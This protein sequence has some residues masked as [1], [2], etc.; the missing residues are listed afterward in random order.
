MLPVA[1]CIAALGLLIFV[2]SFIVYKVL[3]YTC[4]IIGWYFQMQRASEGVGGG[5]SSK[6]SLVPLIFTRSY[7]PGS[8]DITLFPPKKPFGNLP[9]PGTGQCPRKAE[10]S[11]AV[12]GNP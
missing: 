4:S 11:W 7:P 1:I 9:L 8:R 6:L 10:A 2:Q 5:G 3:I 12:P